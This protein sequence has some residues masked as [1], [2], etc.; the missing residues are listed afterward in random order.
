MIKKILVPTDGSDHANKALDLAADLAEKYGAELVIQHV[1]LDHTSA[2]DLAPLAKQYGSDKKTLDTL[3]ETQEAVVQASSV[4]YAGPIFLP[5]PNEA[6]RAIGDAICKSAKARVGSR[7]GGK[8]K[9]VMSS[10]A[11]ADTI[12]NAA[13]GEGADM[14]VMGSRGLGKFADLMMGSVSHR[15]SHMA[16]CTCVTVK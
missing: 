6:L 7:A 1:L 14:I 4:G 10:G 8:V 12:L 2:Y 13:E 16:K 3:E 5:V 11:P 9:V 15:V